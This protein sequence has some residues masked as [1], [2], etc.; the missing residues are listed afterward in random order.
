LIHDIS[1]WGNIDNFKCIIDPDNSF[2]CQ[3]PITDGLLNEVV[4]GVWYQRIY[5]ECQEIA[6]DED[7]VVLR[8][9]LY[10]D[11]LRGQ[12]WSPCHYIH[13]FNRECRYKSEAWHALGYV[14]DLEMKSSAYKSRG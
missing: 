12:E 14:A 6:S 8:A 1:I 4:D 13:N 10:C 11:K 3:L 2:S 9:I 5:A 7:L